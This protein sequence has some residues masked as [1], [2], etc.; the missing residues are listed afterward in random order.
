MSMGDSRGRTSELSIPT[1]L[2][3][4]SGPI[5]LA[6]TG[7]VSAGGDPVAPLASD[8]YKKAETGQ[9]NGGWDLPFTGSVCSWLD[10]VSIFLSGS[11]DGSKKVER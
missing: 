7:K 1:G 5:E 3:K 11:E 9:G 4:H 8:R 2:R 6:G 10:S